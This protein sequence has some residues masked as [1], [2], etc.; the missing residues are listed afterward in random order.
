MTGL[1]PGGVEGA[2][3]AASPAALWEETW[4]SRAVGVRQLYV[5]G[6]VLRQGCGAAAES[7]CV[8][9]RTP[10][11]HRYEESAR[12]IN[13]GGCGTGAP[14]EEW[15]TARLPSTAA[16]RVECA[17]TVRPDSTASTLVIGVN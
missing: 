3:T 15:T 10:A 14:P 11:E 17:N 5:L 7:G 4:S 2:L 8:G 13:L 1:A 12:L 6:H 16:R 9:R